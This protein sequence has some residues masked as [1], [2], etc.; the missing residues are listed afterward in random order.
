MI[1]PAG[2]YHYLT[3]WRS[4]EGPLYDLSRV[5]FQPDIPK[6]TFPNVQGYSF[7]A[8]DASKPNYSSLNII[9]KKF[10]FVHFL[11][12]PSP[13]PESSEIHILTKGINSSG[14][15]L[16]AKEVRICFCNIFS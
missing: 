8:K 5:N 9:L 16:A 15:F 6:A 14:S 13:I 3:M 11:V 12:E 1:N 10:P 2:F 7:E 4:I